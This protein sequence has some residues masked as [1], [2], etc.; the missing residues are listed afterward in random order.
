VPLRLFNVE[1]SMIFTIVT[2]LVLRNMGKILVSITWTWA[3]WWKS[4]WQS[5]FLFSFT[6]KYFVSPSLVQLSKLR[7]S[8]SGIGARSQIWLFYLGHLALLLTRLS[9]LWGYCVCDEGYSRNSSCAFICIFTFLSIII[10]LTLFGNC[11]F[12]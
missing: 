12:Q 4:L 1:C 7:F 2:T 11:K 3:I 9:N 8:P 6:Y 5:S 10:I